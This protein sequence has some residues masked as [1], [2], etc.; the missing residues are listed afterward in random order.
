MESANPWVKIYSTE[1]LYK[2]EIAKGVLEEHGIP[3]V[4]LNKRDSAY[5]NFGYVEVYVNSEYAVK[6]VNLIKAIKYEQ[7]G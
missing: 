3:A 7:S 2:A 1:M 5:Q 4:I 6:A